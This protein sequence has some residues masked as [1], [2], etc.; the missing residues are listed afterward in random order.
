MLASHDGPVPVWCL[1]H[2]Q[3]AARGRRGRAW[4]SPPG[5]FFASVRIAPGGELAGFARYSFVAALALHDALSDLTNAAG[6]IVLKWPNDV[7]VD[8]RKTCGILLETAHAPDRNDLV[9]GFG[10]NLVAAPR[11]DEVEPVAVLP[12]DILSLTGVRLAAPVL[13]DQLAV[14]FD[15]WSSILE[16]DRFAEVRAAWLS[17]ATGLGARITAGLPYATH[18]GVFEDI[19]ADGALVLRTDTGRLV[20]QAADVYFAD[21]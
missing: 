6:R 5:N 21:D 20:L 10:V 18:H 14:R 9:I 13:L 1:A 12:G 16:A 15:Y 19:D 8:G 4:A 3:S 2:R 17:R 11:P 7:L